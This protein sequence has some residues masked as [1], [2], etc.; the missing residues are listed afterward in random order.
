MINAGAYLIRVGPWGLQFLADVIAYESYTGERHPGSAANYKYDQSAMKYVMEMVLPPP[1]R[2]ARPSAALLR[3]A[4]H[5]RQPKLTCT[6]QKR[7]RLAARPP[8][9]VQRL[10]RPPRH[11]PRRYRLGPLAQGR[12]AGPLPRRVQARAGAL[13]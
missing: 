5:R 2:A 3:K 10:P 8:A 1:A 9:L 4:S 13:A 6:G 12:P 7:A 11:A